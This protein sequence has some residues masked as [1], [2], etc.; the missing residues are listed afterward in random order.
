M[1]DTLELPAEL[2]I[3]TA[4]VTRT[5]WLAWLSRPDFNPQGTVQIGGGHVDDIDGAGVQLLGALIQSLAERGVAWRVMAPSAALL[6]ACHILGSQQ[7][8]VGAP[9]QLG[10]P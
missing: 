8:L 4:S 1:H 10:S 7:W 9:A 6:E 5:A 3:Y 2:T